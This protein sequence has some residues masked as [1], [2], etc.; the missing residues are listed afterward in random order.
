MTETDNSFFLPGDRRGVLL[1][2]GL[3][4]TPSE[5]RFV[6]KGLHRAG[7]TVAGMQIVG[8]C[9]DETDLARTNWPDWYAS[10]DAACD[11]LLKHCDTLFIAGLS[12]G[13]M[14]GVLAAARRR[15]VSGL[16]LY[17]PTLWHDGWSV[18]RTRHLLPFVLSLPGSN[19]FSVREQYPFGVKD[20]RLRRRLVMQMVDGNSA[21]AGLFRMPFKVLREI[22][23]ISSETRRCLSTV[24]TP[25]LI[26]HAIEDDV[27]SLRNPRYLAGHLRG[28]V[29]TMYLDDSY[30]M[31]TIDRQRD[32]V[33]R[34]TIDYFNELSPPGV[35]VVSRIAS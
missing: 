32:Q 26:L 30:H 31:I 34:A 3:T 4:G 23:K 17:S 15:D 8:H 35:G 5:M 18:P 10:V 19:R 33:I 6:G 20:E 28:P 7:F 1:V 29:K 2:H 27:A 14:L 25:T 24:T 16:A 21:S 22:R 11:R 9:G 12:M 13:A